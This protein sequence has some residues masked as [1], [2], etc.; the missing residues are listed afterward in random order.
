MTTRGDREPVAITEAATSSTA[1]TRIV[2][3]CG[4]T[5]TFGP[6]GPLRGHTPRG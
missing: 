3:F 1:L 6:T 4:L 5:S 2:V